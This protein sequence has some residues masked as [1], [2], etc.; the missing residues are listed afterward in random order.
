MKRKEV[1]MDSPAIVSAPDQT[2][3]EGGEQ[4]PPGYLNAFGF[5]VLVILLGIA[6][7]FM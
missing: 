4:T 5:H 2:H 6:L 7:A 1:W 3:I